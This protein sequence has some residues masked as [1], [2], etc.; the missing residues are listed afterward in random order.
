MTENVDTPLDILRAFL[1]YSPDMIVLSTFSGTVLHINPAGRALVG[2]SENHPAADLTTVEL[3]TGSG[4]QVAAEVEA[5]LTARGRWSGP[6]ELRHLG[7]DEAIAVMIT[8][9]VVY[10]GDDDS[11]V[12]VASIVRDHR[13]FD[14]RQR[15]QRAATDAA[16]QYG[17]E[18]KAIADLAQLALDGDE[19]DVMDAAVVAASTMV[20]VERAMITRAPDPGGVHGSAGEHGGGPTMTLVAATGVGPQ[21]TPFPAG[22]GT[23]MGLTA[24]TGEVIVCADRQVEN[25]FDTAAMVA[26]GPYMVDATG[27][28]CVYTDTLW[29]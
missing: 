6:S 1:Q 24:S 16:A 22:A 20:G 28:G 10:R 4:L 25:R 14:V 2:L 7:T 9:F 8:T 18:Q 26:Y 29:T 15:E 19:Q 3:F 5:A 23:L 11:S 13:Q 17:A 21:L 12:V 27:G